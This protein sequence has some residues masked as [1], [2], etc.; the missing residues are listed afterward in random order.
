MKQIGCAVVLLLLLSNAAPA[1]EV[2]CTAHA[3]IINSS[4]QRIGMVTFNECAEGVKITVHVTGL[5]PGSR[6]M[7]LHEVGKCQP[8]D[9]KTAGRHFNP[10]GKKHGSK[11]P[12]GPHAGDLPDLVVDQNGLGTATFTTN[13]VTL[14]EGAN[15]LF[16]PAGTSIVIHAK[17]D[18][19]SSDPEGNSGAGMA[20]GVISK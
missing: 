15:S 8:P 1:A 13:L 9:F 17:P 18:D 5:P 10:G 14:R 16:S 2:P 19:Q 11:N 6:G 3:N 7:F 12:E 4:D 20:C